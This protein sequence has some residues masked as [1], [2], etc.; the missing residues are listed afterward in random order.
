MPGI[1][2]ARGNDDRFVPTDLGD[3]ATAGQSPLY[4]LGGR[5]WS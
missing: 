2:G 1:M 5:T 3:P 4:V